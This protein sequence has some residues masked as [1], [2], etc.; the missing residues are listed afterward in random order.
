MTAIFP[1]HFYPRFY[2]LIFGKTERVLSRLKVRNQFWATVLARDYVWKVED[3]SG[4]YGASWAYS[5]IC[6]SK[7]VLLSICSVLTDPNPDDP[8]VP[9]IAHT[10][11]YETRQ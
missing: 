9:E 11:K 6:G 4:R 8:L 10:Y 5:S 3:D 7:E 2:A 1:G